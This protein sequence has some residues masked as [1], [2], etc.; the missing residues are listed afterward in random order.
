MKTDGTILRVMPP[1]LGEHTLLS[2]ENLLESLDADEPF[3]LEL[4]AEHGGISMLVRK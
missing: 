1:R 2:F 4:V 3:S